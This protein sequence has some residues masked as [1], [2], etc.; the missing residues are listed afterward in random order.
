MAGFVTKKVAKHV[1]QENA[2]NRFG[3]DDPYFEHVAAVD[4]NGRATGK[5][6]KRKRAIPPGL[7]KQEE[8]VLKKVTRRAYRLDNCMN[9]CGIRVGWST[10][11]GLIPAA[12]D[13]I[14]ALM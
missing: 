12:G 5:Y 7:T 2:E 14:D 6:E 8:K 10:I 11:I 9:F 4:M 1:L 13:I 3:T